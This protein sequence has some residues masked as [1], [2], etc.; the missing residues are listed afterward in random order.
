MPQKL[1][2]NAIVVIEVDTVFGLFAKIRLLRLPLCSITRCFV[3]ASLKVTPF[4]DLAPLRT[5][6]VALASP[7]AVRIIQ[8][9]VADLR[10]TDF[11]FTV[12]VSVSEDV[13]D[14][15]ADLLRVP[16]EAVEEDIEKCFV[17]SILGVDDALPV[18]WGIY[19]ALDNNVEGFC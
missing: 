8:D 3:D 5:I 10:E 16:H 4:E 14:T 17:A 19:N 9:V 13:L 7:R 6:L 15:F 11:S 2:V 18:A 12:N 1:R